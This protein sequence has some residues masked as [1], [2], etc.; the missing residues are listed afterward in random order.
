[1]T[2]RITLQE[3]DASTVALIKTGLFGTTTNSGNAYSVNVSPDITKLEPGLPIRILIN[4]DSTGAPTLNL[5]GL[6][7][8]PVLK[9][10]G[11]AASFKSGGLFTVVWNG[12]TAFILQGEG[13][14]YG[15][16][17]AADVLSGKTIG[18][19][20]GIIEGTMV[21]MGS[22][23]ILISSVDGAAIPGGYYTG[24]IAKINVIAGDT[25]LYNDSSNR[26][27]TN[28]S[29]TKVKEVR[30]ETAGTYRITFDLSHNN[31]AS[32]PV[33]IQGRIYKNGI[34]HGATYSISPSGSGNGYTP[35]YSSY[36][37]DLYFEA[38]SLCQLYI[39]CPYGGGISSSNYQFKIAT[40]TPVPVIVKMS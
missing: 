23:T 37:Q 15:T 24:G 26:Y 27:T 4:A 14:E 18:K 1:M 30:I 32:Y 13:G 7:A 40:G 12:S 35:G 29:M 34:G 33:N 28:T 3:M 5:N 9:S 11:N 19:E 38:G 36:T 20:N 31:T 17:T 2:K 8:K 10:N 6:G 25:V 22:P 39:C 16:A 21:N